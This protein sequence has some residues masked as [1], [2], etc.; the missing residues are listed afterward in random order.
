MKITSKHSIRWSMRLHDPSDPAEWSMFKPKQA[1][2][3]KQLY[4]FPQLAINRWSACTFMAKQ[5]DIKPHI[6]T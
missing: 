1:V 2:R 6:C 4:C 3:D 5:T